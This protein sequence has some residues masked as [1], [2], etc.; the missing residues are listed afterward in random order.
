MLLCSYS[1]VYPS[2]AS[3]ESFK[4]LQ[5]MEIRSTFVSDASVTFQR[6]K[7]SRDTKSFAPATTSCR[8]STCFPHPA[9]N[10]RNWSFTITSFVLW[11]RS[12][13]MQTSSP[14]SS[15]L[16]DKQSKQPT[17]SS[18]KC[19]PQRPSAA[20]LSAITINWRWWRS[21]RMRSPSSW[22]FSS[23]VRRRSWRS[24]EQIGPWSV[25]V[26]RKWGIGR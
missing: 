2:P 3:L 13:S 10:R 6:R 22:T 9:P 21:E 24:F 7:F 15:R 11:H 14:F 16:I 12:W 5:N 20:R 17:P 18:T 8:C 23:S 4:T 19:A 25:W 1:Q 26:V